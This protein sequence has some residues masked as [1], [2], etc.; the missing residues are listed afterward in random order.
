MQLCRAALKQDKQEVS[1][2][3]IEIADVEEQGYI[4]LKGFE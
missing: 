2:T 1:D 4:L 3:L